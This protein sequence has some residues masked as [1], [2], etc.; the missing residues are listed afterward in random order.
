MKKLLASFG[1]ALQGLFRVIKNERN[2]KIHLLAFVLVC[3]LGFYFSITAT[4]WIFIL[5]MSALVMSLEILNTSIESLCDRISLE[6]DEKIKFIKDTAAA[7]VLVAAAL[8]LLIGVLIF[9][10]YFFTQE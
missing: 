10:P 5:T 9:Y 7:A 6:R 4:E 3:F 8:A 1:F 2:F